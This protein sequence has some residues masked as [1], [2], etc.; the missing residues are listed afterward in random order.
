MDATAHR[1]G[2]LSQQNKAHKRSGGHQSKGARRT[3][4]KGRVERAQAGNKVREGVRARAGNA[5]AARQA[6][7]GAAKQQRQKK[8]EALLER[9]R[10]VGVT[11]APPKIVVPVWCGDL[12]PSALTD[13]D[14]V[15]AELV[16]GIVDECGGAPASAV[17]GGERVLYSN[18]WKQYFSV[19]R[20]SDR[21]DLLTVLD[22]VKLADVV[23]LV[24]PLAGDDGRVGGIS[25]GA[26]ALLSMIKGQG[27]PSIVG[28]VVDTGIP[29]GNGQVNLVKARKAVLKEVSTQFDHRFPAGVNNKFHPVLA[30]NAVQRQREIQTLLRVIVNCPVKEMTWRESRPYL[31]V[32]AVDSVPTEDPDTPNFL[33]VTGFLRGSNL[34]ANNLLHVSNVGTFQVDRITSATSPTSGPAAVSI[35]SFGEAETVLA[36]PDPQKQE[37]LE[38][39]MEADPF[40]ADQPEITEADYVNAHGGVDEL[41][42]NKHTKKKVAVPQGTSDYQANWFVSSSEGEGEDSDADPFAVDTS[43]DEER[44][45][46]DYDEDMGMLG[47]GKVESADEHIDPEARAEEAEDDFDFPDEVQAPEDQDARVR[48]QKF[49]GLKSFQNTYWDPKESLPHEYAKIV[50]FD[51]QNQA[52]VETDAFGNAIAGGRRRTGGAFLGINRAILEQQSLVTPRDPFEES[53]V[54]ENA[55]LKGSFVTLW[56]RCRDTS[57]IQAALEQLQVKGVCI[58][59]GLLPFENR[60][61]VSHVQIKAHGEGH[62]DPLT[63]EEVA[64]VT[65]SKDKVILHVGFRRIHCRPIFSQAKPADKHKYERFLHPRTSAM[66]SF[67]GPICFPQGAPVLMTSDPALN[68]G[69]AD[70]HVASQVSFAPN[71]VAEGIAERPAPPPLRLLGVGSVNSTDP[72][73]LALKRIILTGAPI[74]VHKKTVTVRGMFFNADDIRW[75]KPVELWS[76]YGRI[77]HISEPLGTHGLMKCRFDLPVLQHDTIC[78]SLYKRVFPPWRSHWNEDS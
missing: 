75:F 35:G 29:L 32:D 14:A 56:L 52:S 21:S 71:V 34:D 12:S 23:L 1:R 19:I 9:R 59:S 45:R 25:E 46:Q 8:R 67:Y 30:T 5:E 49:R 78:M 72:D 36:V 41:L 73:R 77:G 3:A 6:R 38:P 28:V 58:A 66:A 22:A 76:K 40:A 70:S 61:S 24:M 60:V 26:E 42:H 63:G 50:Q 64:H 48:F 2:A 15:V 44:A 4:N 68:D 69:A 27:T 39:E 16:N 54:P 43:S 31:C 37:A 13:G 11:G 17:A 62:V 47:G 20:S 7:H 55:V 57:K 53:E 51:R 65:K 10:S 33:R 74:K 18:A